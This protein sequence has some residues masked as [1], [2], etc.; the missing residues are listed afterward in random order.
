MLQRARTPM[1]H[2]RV[3]TW[4]PEE[5]RCPPYHLIPLRQD[6]SLKLELDWQPASLSLA[7]KELELQ[8]H[9]WPHFGFYV[10]AGDSNLALPACVAV[11]LPMKPRPT[12]RLY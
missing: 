6:H 5:A 3:Y 7:L 8:A 11:L 10:G 12:T 9:T 1:W 2:A 4:R